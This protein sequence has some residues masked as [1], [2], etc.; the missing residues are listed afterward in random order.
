MAALWNYQSRLFTVEDVVVPGETLPTM[1]WNAVAQ[2]GDKIAMR[3][4]ELGVW[5][6]V[7]WRQFG[8]AAREVGLGLVALGMEPG[9]VV[10]VLANT[11]KEWLYADLGALG[12]GCVSNGIYPTDSPEQVHYLSADSATRILFVED[13]EQ[14]D[15]ALEVRARLPRPAQDRRVRHQGPGRI[16]RSGR[17]GLRG[18]A[19]ARPRARDAQPGALAAAARTRAGP[20]TWRS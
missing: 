4:K 13:E 10:S 19:R 15:K 12:A 8:D 14:L 1:F 17:D 5:R 7:T 18:A 6:S 11:R 9:E 20:T 3:Q 16:Q 2:R